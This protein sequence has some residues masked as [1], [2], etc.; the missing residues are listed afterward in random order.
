MSVYDFLTSSFINHNYVII[1]GHNL[2]YIT[3]GLYALNGSL[4]DTGNAVVPSFVLET[5]TIM[6]DAFQLGPGLKDTW[7]YNIDVYAR[8]DGERDDI[9]ELLRHFLRPSIPI[10]DYNV[11]I[12]G[13]NYITLAHGEPKNI[14]AIF[15]RFDP[16]I[17]VLRHTMRVYF[18]LDVFINSGN[19]LVT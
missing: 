16:K 15:D 18:D 8:S 19:T 13:G 7:H 2:P 9:G 11:I 12:S 1:S 10:Y 6:D 14:V 3:S 17:R 5:K 4:V